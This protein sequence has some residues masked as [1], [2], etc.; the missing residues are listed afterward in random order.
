MADDGTEK[1]LQDIPE[2]H[3]AVALAQIEDRLAAQKICHEFPDLD[4]GD[5]Y[6]VLR[7][8]RLS[9]IE[10]LYNSLKRGRVFAR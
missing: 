1:L 10:R 5:C 8:L 7:N 2:E 4:P 9:P 6:H 3:R